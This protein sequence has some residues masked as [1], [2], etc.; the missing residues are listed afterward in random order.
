[1]ANS[2]V[3]SGCL[4]LFVIIL[5]LA[6]LVGGGW[7]TVKKY[8]TLQQKIALEINEL[9]NSDQES[10][11]EES[12]KEAAEKLGLTIPVKKPSLTREKINKAI[13]KEIE[14]LAELKTLYSNLSLQTKAILKKYRVA[15]K[16]DK[17]SFLLNT[18]GKHVTGIF[19]G[20]FADRKGELIKVDQEEYRIHDVE[21]DY[22]YHFNKVLSRKRI[23]EELAIRKKEF[24]R[25]RE[26]IIAK[27]KKKIT[28][29]HYTQAGYK[30]QG[31]SWRSNFEIYT[32]LMNK[33]LS[34]KK[35][36]QIQKIYEK[37]K[38]FG[39]IDVRDIEKREKLLRGENDQ[40]Q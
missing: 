1:M 27:N 17:V 6:L 25:K 18:T 23:V 20:A 39:V 33:L 10:I 22:L 34:E 36:A 11:K 7:Y 13:T 4:I 28:E 15:K 19:K 2:N 24:K 30:K 35:E 5:S 32:D 29:K 3:K 21:E 40:K 37:N 38:L 16:G 31:D 14:E 8:K 12:E 26:D 9:S